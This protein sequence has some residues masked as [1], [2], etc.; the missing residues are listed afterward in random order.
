MKLSFS[1]G[2]IIT[3]QYEL[4]VRLK[5]ASKTML[6]A[7]VDGL[8]LIGGA[9]VLSAVGSGLKWSIKLDNAEQLE[10]LSKEIGVAIEFY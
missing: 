10:L 5:N 9:N 7:E 1:E 3:N 8:T 6:Q 4:V 2:D